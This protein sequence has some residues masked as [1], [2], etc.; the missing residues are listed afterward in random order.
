MICLIFPKNCS[1]FYLLRTL[2]FFYESESESS[3]EKTINKELKKL[4][5]WLI[6]NRLALNIDK[7]NFILF[8]PF[9]KKLKSNI[10]LIINKK[11]V[12]QTDSIKY[13]GIIIDSSLSWK[14]HIDK[15]VSKIRCALGLMYKIRPYVFSTT[16]L[17]LYYSLTYPHL[18]Y[19][20][21]IW[22]SANIIQINR[23][24]ILQK[25]AVRII[26]FKDRRQNNFAFPESNPLFM[27]L[28]VLKIHDI[29]TLNILLFV[30]KC[31]HKHCLPQFFSWFVKSSQIH[32]HNTRSVTENNLSIPHVRTTSY[33]LKSIKFLGPKMWNELPSSIKLNLS[34]NSFLNTVKQRLISTI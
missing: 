3:L 33:G 34:Y 10:T 5:S 7:T 32:E 8:H 2:T 4:H 1:F 16:L 21:E 23:L 11:A 14:N 15:V 18:L 17:T 29:F 24:L 30:F 31:L 19:G 9:N 13:L 27:K 6:V 26:S 12:K 25:R 20:I 28:K 22:G